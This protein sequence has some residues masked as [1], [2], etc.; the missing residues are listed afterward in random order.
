MRQYLLQAKWLLH[1]PTD[2]VKALS[3]ATAGFLFNQLAYFHKSCSSLN[4]ANFWMIVCC[5][6]LFTG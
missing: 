6:K 4:Q 3:N 1:R 2:N 5:S